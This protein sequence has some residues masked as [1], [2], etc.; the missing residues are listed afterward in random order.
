MRVSL[1]ALILAPPLVVGLALI[2]FSRASRRRDRFHTEGD[3]VDATR[4]DIRSGY[5]NAGIGFALGLAAFAVLFAVLFVVIGRGPVEGHRLAGV[6]IGAGFALLGAGIGMMNSS[7]R[8]ERRK[9]EATG[10]DRGTRR[11]INSVVLRGKSDPLSA[12]EQRRA[13]RF[14]AIVMQSLPFQAVQGVALIGGGLLSQVAD[15]VWPPRGIDPARFRKEELLLIAV[16]TA[17]LLLLPTT[18]LRA[19]RRAMR[20][21]A[22]AA[23]R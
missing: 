8:I 11:R 7:A 9:R 18:M 1:L 4:A 3:W 10:T 22:S 19:R 14:A 17:L 23:S 16:C 21:A 20:W 2:V 13:A 15:I 6:P 12:E 5:R